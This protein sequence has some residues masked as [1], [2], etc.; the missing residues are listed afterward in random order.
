MNR[1]EEINNELKIIKECEAAYR[2]WKGLEANSMETERAR[3]SYNMMLGRTYILDSTIVTI[4]DV[5]RYKQKLIAERSFI[6]TSETKIRFEKWL[7]KPNHNKF[8]KFLKNKYGNNLTLGFNK[9]VE[10]L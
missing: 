3:L 9:H 8:V 4:Y 10:E 7:D 5:R 6:K 2:F 1:I